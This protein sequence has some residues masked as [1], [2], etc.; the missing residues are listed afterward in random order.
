[1]RWNA[2]PPPATSELCL[3]IGPSEGGELGVC[4]YPSCGECPR[5]GTGRGRSGALARPR[6]GRLVL[7]LARR[8]VVLPLFQEL[9][10]VPSQLLVA[11]ADAYQV[12]LLQL[13]EIQQRVLS[14]FDRTDQ[15]VQLDLDRPA[16]AVLGVLDQEDH[17]EGDDRGA[18]VYHQLP[19]VAE[20]EDRP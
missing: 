13:L 4:L 9:A 20:A 19:R 6:G 10:R 1:M 15:L 18:G 12:V 3:V 8:S 17:K 2:L 14:A 11:L 5:Q 7:S 16:V